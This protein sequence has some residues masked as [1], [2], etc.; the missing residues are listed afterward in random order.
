ML[1]LMALIVFAGEQL[2]GAAG[3][4][5]L[6]NEPTRVWDGELWR[7]LTTVL[8]HGGIL[9]LFFNCYALAI[10]GTVT[11]R[12]LGSNRYFGLIILLAL[13][14]SATQ[15]LVHPNPSVGL[16]GVVYGLFGFLFAIRLYKDYARV[17]MT[18]SVM[19]QFI[20]WFVLCWILTYAA[21]WPIANYA[22]LGGLAVGWLVGKSMLKRRTSMRIAGI[23]AG[24]VVLSI[25]TMYMPWNSDYRKY[26][27]NKEWIR[28]NR[29]GRLPLD[30]DF[31]D[32]AEG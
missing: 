27:A 8:P 9:H 17:V 10:L 2:P 7:L 30:L 28:A 5:F 31:R 22:H 1:V 18:D 20:G 29:D 3:A 13:G 24:V 25:M 16:S 23:A 15:F 14:A 26:Q 11:E 6:W 19:K 21:G 32:S 4:Q 12:A